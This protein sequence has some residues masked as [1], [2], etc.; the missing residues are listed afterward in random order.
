MDS[1]IPQCI[2][3]CREQSMVTSRA[4]PPHNALRSSS[5]SCV[6]PAD[7]MPYGTLAQSQIESSSPEPCTLTDLCDVRVTSP[8]SDWG[9][10]GPRAPHW[11]K[12]IGTALTYLSRCLDDRWHRCLDDT[13]DEADSSIPRPFNSALILKWKQKKKK[14]WH[15]PSNS[16][17][18]CF[19]SWTT[20]NWQ[21]VI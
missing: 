13:Q 12:R 20:G 8:E 7:W 10:E 2:W 17:D 15:W 9:W 3:I 11:Y 19:P 1:N 16:T 21:I 14:D 18:A 5:S 4:L 6:F